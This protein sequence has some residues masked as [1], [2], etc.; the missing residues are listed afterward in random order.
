MKKKF[1]T[2]NKGNY[3]IENK[4]K[5]LHKRRN[6]RKIR[7]L[8]LLVIIMVSTLIT[9]CFKLPYFN[10]AKIEILGNVNVTAAEIN[11]RSNIEVGNN[12][13]F[14]NFNHSKKEIMKNPYILGV[15]I[16]KVIPNR[17]I[18]KI[19]ERIAVFYGKVNDTYYI[20]D[21][22]VILLE[23]KNNIKDMN[24]VNLIGFDYEKCQVGNLIVSEDNRKI[25]IA[26]EI[27]NIINDYRKVNSNSKIAMVD[28][29]DV[30]NLK[31]FYGEMCIKFGTSEDLKNKF[32]RAINIV[33]Q[34]EYKNTKGYVDVSFKGNPVV[35]IEEKK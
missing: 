35:F 9:L 3:I 23:K 13:F 15:K 2:L 28:V 16:R 12:I 19:E 33:S 11:D 21:N 10:I 22:K 18:I 1:D 31:I 27:T 6:K 5:L 7:R 24:L 34:P 26:N 20:L 17:V 4:E 30:L 29:S 14:A 8:M 32:N 25:N